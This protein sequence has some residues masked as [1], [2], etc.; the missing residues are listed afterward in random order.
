MTHLNLAI[1][2]LLVFILFT[3]LCCWVVWWL[4][5]RHYRVQELMAGNAREQAWQQ[6]LMEV[7]HSISLKSE[8]SLVQQN[9]LQEA[10][11][12][13]AILRQ[14]VAALTEKYSDSKTRSAEQ[15]MTIEHLSQQ[16]D[17]RQQLEDRYTQLLGDHHALQAKRD[18]ESKHYQSQLTLIEASKVQLGKE[19]EQLAHKIFDAKQEQFTRQSKVSLETSINPLREQLQSF[20]EKVEHV[21]EKE[22]ADRNKLVGQITELQ[23]QTQQI[24]QDAVNLAKALKGDNKAQGN[25]GEV[26]LERLLEQSGLTKGREYDTQVNLAGESGQRRNPDVIIR[27]PE[28][29]DIVIDAKVSLVDYERYCSTDDPLEQAAALKGHINSL[30]GHISQLSVKDYENLDGIRSLDF[31]FIFVPIEAAFMLALQHDQGLFRDAYDKHIILVSPT[32]LLAT[33]RTVEN[34]WRY[35]KQNKN[36]EKIAKQAGALYDQFVLLL[37][38]MDDVGKHLGKAQEAFDTTQKRLS[39]GR[40]NLIRRV[41]DIKLLGAKTK[42]QIHAE[43]LDQ[44][45]YSALPD[46]ADDADFDAGSFDSNDSDGIDD[47]SFDGVDAPSAS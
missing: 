46:L 20:R 44:L 6:Q 14:E 12:Q 32:T 24:G 5:R 29:K 25:W 3:A 11:E 1:N 43:K 33:L 22:A 4:S 15:Q 28:N 39:T 17:K 8:Q 18:E 38:S 21:Y 36:A 40:G 27:L 42:K 45:D 19:F 34:I 2:Q 26:I 31:V 37:S 10:Q 23:R 16:L 35:E 7:N 13:I 41:E 30:R 9:R 47:D